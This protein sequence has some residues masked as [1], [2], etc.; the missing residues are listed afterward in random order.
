VHGIVAPKN[1]LHRRVERILDRDTSRTS[2]GRTMVAGSLMGALAITAGLAALTVKPGLAS[3]AVTPQNASAAR[4]AQVQDAAAAASVSSQAG[5]ID[6]DT[7]VGMRAAGITVD[8]MQA[9]KSEGFA[10]LTLDQG[11]ALNDAGVTP[12][13]AHALL[14]VGM[15]ANAD[16]L[17]GA[18]TLGLT[19]DYIV[20]MR[21]LGIAGTFADFKTAW[22]AGITPDIVRGYRARG[23]TVTSTR[24]LVSLQAAGADSAR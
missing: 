19:P 2:P 16:A 21:G 14:A 20:T 23:V 18:H 12:A 6:P 10:H 11:I 15:P 3:P 24:Q 5:P 9:M 4:L 22:M 7:L 1:S 13:D 8:Y 17:L